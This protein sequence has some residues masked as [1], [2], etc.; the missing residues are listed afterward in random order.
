MELRKGDYGYD[1]NFTVKKSD[2]TAFDLTDYASGIKFRVRREDTLVNL[3]D[4]ACVVV[5]ASAGTCKYTVVSGN[6]S[7]VG[8]FIGGLVM[9]KT[10][11]VF[12]SKD[13]SISVKD[14]LKP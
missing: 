6:F 5:S 3:L 4:G 8:N 2:G 7:D 14:P 13:I 12:T 1:I 11:S 10:G 9:T